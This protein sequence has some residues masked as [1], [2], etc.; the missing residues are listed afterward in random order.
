MARFQD[1]TRYIIEHDPLRLTDIKDVGK[2]RAQLIHESWSRWSGINLIME[3]LH[4]VHISPKYALKIY[5][6]YGQ[7]S[8]KNVRLNP[9]RYLLTYFLLL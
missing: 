3:F 1:E 6:R 5:E 7:D 2:K 8:I 9:Y 4:S